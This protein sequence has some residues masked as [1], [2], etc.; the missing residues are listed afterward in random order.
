MK[1]LILTQKVDENDDVLGFMHGWIKEFAKHYEKIIVVAL[2][3]GQY[4]LP[5]N[6]KVLSLGKPVQGGPLGRRKNHKQ[7]KSFF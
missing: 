4:D 6:V 3:V 2:G 7:I 5:E 1:L